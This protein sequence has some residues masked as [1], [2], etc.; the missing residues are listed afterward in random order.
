MSNYLAL[1]HCERHLQ[2]SS[3]KFRLFLN[4]VAIY[5]IINLIEACHISLNDALLCPM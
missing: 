3:R 4:G 5:N 2:L 1:S